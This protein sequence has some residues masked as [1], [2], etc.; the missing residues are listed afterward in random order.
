M[1]YNANS[2]FNG[3]Y[4]PWATADPI[5]G[6]VTVIPSTL[7][8]L[9]LNLD[10]EGYVASITSIS[11]NDIIPNY[12]TTTEFVISS[13][14]DWE[15]YASSNKSFEGKVLKLA[16]D[17]DAHGATLPM[18]IL[19]MSATNVIFDGCG[20]TIKNV[21]TASAANPTPLIAYQLGAATIK[22]VNFENVYISSADGVGLIAFNIAAN[23]TTLIENI[24]ISNCHVTS[25]ANA[26]GAL[27]GASKDSQATDT[28]TV[29]NITIDANT[30]ISGAA[31]TGGLIGDVENVGTLNIFN[32]YTAAKVTGSSNTFYVGGLIGQSNS[33]VNGII[34]IM[35]CYIG[36]SVE[37]T[38]DGP[39]GGVAGRFTGYAGK[40]ITAPDGS[41][42]FETAK[43][44]TIKNIILDCQFLLSTARMTAWIG[45]MQGQ[46]YM[47]YDNIMTTNTTSGNRPKPQ[48]KLVAIN[49]N[50]MINGKPM[51]GEIPS[52][53]AGD[54]DDVLF[55]EAKIAKTLVIVD[56]ETGFV[57]SVNALVEAYTYQ[58]SEV[59]DGKYSIRFVGTS[60]LM[61]E[62]TILMHVKATTASGVVRNFTVQSPGMEKLF[63]FDDH[64]ID[65][66]IVA[67]DIG[68]QKMLSV[69]VYDIP[70]GEDITFEFWVTMAMPSGAI[71]TSTQTITV[72][73]DAT[74][75]P[76]V[77][78]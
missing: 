6:S 3:T 10:E 50:T 8:D 34:N 70:V 32:V 78:A 41:I 49:S 40:T 55:V 58:Y 4:N 75:A 19:N 53:S 23:G 52:P 26:A 65:E 29:R 9:M 1:S 39:L 46:G 13:I 44:I 2:L 28:V 22:N 64:N 27:V 12:D 30:V 67:A 60:Q 71:V 63:P 76:V 56:E 16:A 15:F 21:G 43:T 33:T 68:V 18:L 77:A 37:S 7:I 69:T 17:I 48:W 36:G 57:K 45:T 62:E 74:G 20:Y 24:K 35:N 42:S 31:N 47:Y 54:L 66:S 51:N 14:E 25:T 5:Q 11:E 72:T 38:G 59:T 61:T 73:F